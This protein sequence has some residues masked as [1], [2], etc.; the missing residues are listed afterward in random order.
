[1]ES[2]RLGVVR[3][4]CKLVLVEGV[5]ISDV[6]TKITEIATTHDNDDDYGDSARQA[7]TTDLAFSYVIAFFLP[8]LT[9]CSLGCVFFHKWV[10]PRGV[11]LVKWLSAGICVLFLVRCRY[12]TT[13]AQGTHGNIYMS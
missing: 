10:A 1:M 2:V 13:V 12:S 11:L 7:N 9:K 3:G 5:S 6:T 8:D 4:S